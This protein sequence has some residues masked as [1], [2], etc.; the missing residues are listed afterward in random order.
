MWAPLANLLLLFIAIGA[1]VVLVLFPGEEW[2]T[3]GAYGAIVVVSLL[4][5]VFR[6]KSTQTRV[7]TL[8][9]TC[10]L[11]GV[12]L[13]ISSKASLS[14]SAASLSP[15]PAPKDSKATFA[16]IPAALAV[17]AIPAFVLSE[18]RV[19]GSTQPPAQASAQP[20]PSPPAQ[21][22]AQPQPSPP[23]QASAQPPARPPAASRSPPAQPSPPQAQLPAQRMNKVQELIT[24]LGFDCQIQSDSNEFVTRILDRF[25]NLK[26]SFMFK[27]SK[28]T[29]CETSD[30]HPFSSTN[31]ILDLK[32][33]IPEEVNTPVII[34]Q[35][36]QD[37]QL[38]RFEETRLERCPD[39]DHRHRAKTTYQNFSDFV[40]IH[41]KVFKYVMETGVSEK[42]DVSVRIE[43]QLWLG[44]T[45]YVTGIQYDLIGLVRHQGQSIDRGHY[46]ADVKRGDIWWRADD[47]KITPLR[48]EPN[49]V[50]SDVYML[51]YRKAG[52]Q[53]ATGVPEPLENLGAS[54]YANAVIQLLE[55]TGTFRL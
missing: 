34:S 4:V 55:T 22:S 39:S 15:S 35:M 54:C 16:V 3:F 18:K 42:I 53:G 46:I 14:P 10:I 37:Q 2:A 9:S 45:Q 50:Q 1:I 24:N 8:A 30:D 17:I 33:E 11:V 51:L 49:G 36:I 40:L 32:I 44:G 31:I 38:E 48:S 23:A 27:E 7:Y 6:M 12:G 21:A 47:A 52:V 25:P 13:M 20:Q 43:N 28:V 26:P 41:M 19:E 5:I 29:N